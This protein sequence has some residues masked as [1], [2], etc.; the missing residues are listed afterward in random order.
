MAVSRP[1][2]REPQHGKRYAERR[3][4]AHRALHA[5]GSA[6]IFDDAPG[7]GE[8]EP[9]ALARRFRGEKGLEHSIDGVRGYSGSRISHLDRNRSIDV[10]TRDDADEV[11]VF[12]IAGN[13]LGRIEEQVQ[14]EAAQPRFVYSHRRDAVEFRDDSRAV[15]GLGSCD[16][17]AR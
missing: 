2:L 7:N 5:D 12:R 9:S 1:V 11:F 16:F 17:D 3:A 13:G 10:V 8:A 6:E 14:E 4:P 15:I